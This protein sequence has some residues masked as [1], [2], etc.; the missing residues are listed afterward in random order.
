MF[1]LF[2]KPERTDIWSRSRLIFA[3]VRI[4]SIRLL[5]TGTEW[6]DVSIT[7][8]ATSQSSQVVAVTKSR[9]LELLQKFAVIV[10]TYLLVYL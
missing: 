4:K 10:F 9:V 8:V 6:T 1:V 7:D 2:L 3:W 5:N